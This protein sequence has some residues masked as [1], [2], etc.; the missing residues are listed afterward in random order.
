MV[1]SEVL[2]QFKIV[3]FS[4]PLEMKQKRKKSK[5]TYLH[6]IEQEQCVVINFD[7]KIQFVTKTQVDTKKVREIVSQNL[8]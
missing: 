3:G 8:T 5:N 2:R 4:A 1:L 6:K 7:I